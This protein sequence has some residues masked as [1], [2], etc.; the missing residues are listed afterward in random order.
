MT[1][2]RARWLVPLACAVALGA[3]PCRPAP[4]TTQTN[5]YYM[6]RATATDASRLGCF[7]SGRSGRMTL[8][9]GAPTTVN[10]TYGATL[11]GAPNRTTSEIAQSVQNFIRGYAYCRTDSRMRLLIVVGT[12]NSAIDGKTT[13]WLQNHGHAWALMVARLNG[14]AARYY[15]GHAQVYGAWDFE[16]AW[17]TFT[18]AEHWMLGYDRTSGRRPLYANSSADGCPT[19]TATNGPC[20]NGWDQNRVWHL[21][22]H[23]DPS[24]P[25]PQI[26]ATSGVNAHQW[27]L[28]DLWATVHAGDGMYFYGTMS[29]AGACR[30]VGG[31]A[32]MDNSPRAAHDYLLQWLRS[33]PRTSQPSVDTITDIRWNS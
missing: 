5:S 33:D 25:I 21:A 15:P 8:S 30:Q 11:W 29:Q 13:Q 19:S 22:W 6:A 26:Y 10:G 1:L 7:N 3:A 24:M 20:D 32:G 12:S 14:W 28:I 27:Q 17:S 23:H 2:R 16:P 18:K 31:C 9:F 4:I